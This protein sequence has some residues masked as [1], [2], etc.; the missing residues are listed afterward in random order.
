MRVTRLDVLFQLPSVQRFL[1]RL[2]DDFANRR[3]LLILLPTGVDPVELRDVMRA[4]LWRRDFELE[5]VSLVCLPNPRERPP[6]AALSE[7]L[8]INWAFDTPRTVLN[9]METEQLPDIIFLDDLD[10]LSPETC[11]DWVAFLGQWA[12]H[13]QRRIDRGSSITALCV[14]GPAVGV[15][16]H[17]PESSVHLAVHW[18]WGFPSALETRVLCRS[19]NEGGG[20]NTMT[21][22]REHMLPALSGNDV[23]L[24]DALWDVLHKDVETLL[25]CLH[26]LAGQRGWEAEALRSWGVGEGSITSSSNYDFTPLF[27]PVDL[28]LLWAHGA[29]GW[30]L[31]YG[32][33]LHPAALAALGR[34]DELRHRLWR[35]QAELIFPLVDRIRLEICN[36]LTR[37]HGSDWPVRWSPPTSLEEDAAV[38][39]SP[40]AC[41]WGHL[42]ALLSHGALRRSHQNWL[43]LI[44][45][46][47]S[48][49]NEIAHYRPI[50][51]HDFEG[52]WREVERASVPGTSYL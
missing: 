42:K 17:L 9:L 6:V 5:E 18:W 27:P 32:L 29:I 47:H 34:Q 44:T 23:S 50:T 4:E 48:I 8:G 14:M 31:E 30:T 2:M 46:V 16:P 40:L 38:R 45:L 49:R 7:A 39:Q 36:H 26:T 3:S 1:N 11:K 13:C 24:V 12:Q 51:F 25:N 52:F 28:R 22:W 41:Q 15:L 43:P 35:G 10:Q 19:S 21:R 33:E 37:A 20:W